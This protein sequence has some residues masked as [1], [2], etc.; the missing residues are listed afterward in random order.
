MVSDRTNSP[1]P[2]LASTRF[3]M[4]LEQ[5]QVGGSPPESRV[6]CRESRP[7]PV[8]FLKALPVILRLEERSAIAVPV[9][10]DLERAQHEVV[11]FEFDEDPVEE[12]RVA[13]QTPPELY[14]PGGVHPPGHKQVPP[15]SKTRT[16]GSL[17]GMVL[18]P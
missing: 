12:L 4:P 5:G 14:N 9:F 10:V 13:P 7:F 16:N 6:R 2:L 18:D 8:A 15:G 11:R 3:I 17:H 1:L